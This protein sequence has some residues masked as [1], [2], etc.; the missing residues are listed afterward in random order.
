MCMMFFKSYPVLFACSGL[1]VAKLQALRCVR[2]ETF[3][4]ARKDAQSLGQMPWRE[5]KGRIVGPGLEHG[6]I[7]KRTNVTL[8]VD[9]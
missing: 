7:Y 3:T 6:D 9:H 4:S 5:A 8:N 2:L 1:G